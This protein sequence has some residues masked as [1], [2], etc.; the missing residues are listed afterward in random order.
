MDIKEVRKKIFDRDHNK[1]YK[2]GSTKRLCMD[3]VNPQSIFH[4]HGIDNILTLCWRCNK[5]KYTKILPQNEIEEIKKYLTES[6]QK[7][8][9]NEADEMAKIIEEFY[10]TPKR[11]IKRVKKTDWRDL[12]VP[13]KNGVLRAWTMY[14]MRD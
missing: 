9:T 8:T 14:R 1:C 3:H 2:C 12:A 6:N 13:D 10:T 5:S 4:Y 11:K 7:F